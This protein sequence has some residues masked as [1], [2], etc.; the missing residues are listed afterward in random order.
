MCVRR[1]HCERHA[2]LAFV[3]DRV[4]AKFFVDVFVFAFAEEVKVQIAERR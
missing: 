4:R 2:A 3:R 1:P